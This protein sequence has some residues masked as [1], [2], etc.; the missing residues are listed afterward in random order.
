MES[1]L[2][3]IKNFI[4]YLFAVRPLNTL[5]LITN[6]NIYSASFRRG[7]KIALIWRVMLEFRYRERDR[8]KLKWLVILLMDYYII[9]QIAKYEFYMRLD[10]GRK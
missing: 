2:R 7:I 4:R 5:A 9:K 10:S 3:D 6:R 8:N 1:L